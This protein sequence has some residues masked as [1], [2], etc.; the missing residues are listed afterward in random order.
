[1]RRRRQTYR[2]E[3]VSPICTYGDIEPY[4][5]SYARLRG[6]MLV[7]KSCGIHIHLDA[8]PNANTLRNITNIM[9]QRRI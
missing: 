5:R 8:R 6:R 4:R 3:L 9:A 1:M 7:N 2:V